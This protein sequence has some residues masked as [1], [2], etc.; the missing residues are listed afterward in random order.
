MKSRA[1]VEAFRHILLPPRSEQDFEKVKFSHREA[2][3]LADKYNL[4]L[5]FLHGAGLSGAVQTFG[6]AALCEFTITEPEMIEAYLKIDH[7]FNMKCHEI[8]LD[9][10]VDIVRRNGFYECCD[11]FSPAM[12]ERF[13]GKSLAE[14][15]QLTHDAGAVIGYTLLTGIMPML[16]NLDRLDFDCIICPGYILYRRR[17]PQDQLQTWSAQELLDRAER[18]DPYALGQA[19]RGPQGDPPGFRGVWKGRSNHH[20]VFVEQG[21]LPWANVLAMIDEWQK[22]R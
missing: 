5:L 6:P 4:A 20:P 19:G 17:W 11:F 21:G 9:L 18:Y 14:E 13:L 2:S 15:I 22:L 8:A 12:L 1:D 16:D 7:R 3:L 10:G